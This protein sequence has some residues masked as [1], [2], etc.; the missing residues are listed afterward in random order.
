MLCFLPNTC[1]VF[2]F[3]QQMASEK[4]AILESSLLLTSS[5]FYNVQ[6]QIKYIQIKEIQ[7]EY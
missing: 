5:I 7:K 2:Y 6:Q 4:K 1:P 3:V